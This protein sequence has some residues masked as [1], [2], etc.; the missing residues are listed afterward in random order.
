MRDD[1]NRSQFRLRPTR[2]PYRIDCSTFHSAEQY[3][4]K[5]DERICSTFHLPFEISI[6]A[7]SGSRLDYLV[8]GSLRWQEK[9]KRCDTDDL[10][11]EDFSAG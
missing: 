1:R 4:R 3:I 6:P 8:T 10:M 5:K 2:H 7:D 9:R 11:R